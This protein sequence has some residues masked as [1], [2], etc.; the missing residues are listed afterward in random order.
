MDDKT[1]RISCRTPT[2]GKQPTSIP[3]WKFELL[4][5]HILA[6]VPEQPPG[7]KAADLPG[8]VRDRLSA[9]D[10]ETLGSVNWHVTTVKLEL[11]VCGE[12]QRVDAVAPQHLIQCRI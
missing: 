1:D 11:E 7:I 3:R 2:P 5:E 10:L 9:A 12:I 4:R 6:L 8:L